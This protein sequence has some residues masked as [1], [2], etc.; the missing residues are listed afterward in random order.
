VRRGSAVSCAQVR[1]DSEPLVIRRPGGFVFS[2]CRPP[3]EAS[4]PVALLGGER[5]SFVDDAADVVLEAGSAEVLASRREFRVIRC[6]RARERCD[7]SA[8]SC[9]SRQ[10]KSLPE[11]EEA[12]SAERLG[13]GCYRAGSVVL[14]QDSC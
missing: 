12:S 11:Q 8:F 9:P 10:W 3:E 7:S 4:D 14:A 1:Q 2:S 13:P 5:G 6:A